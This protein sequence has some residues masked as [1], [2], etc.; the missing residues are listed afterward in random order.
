MWISSRWVGCHGNIWT[1]EHDLKSLYF[2]SNLQYFVE[3]L[4]EQQLLEWKADGTSHGGPGNDGRPC[5]L[6]QEIWVCMEPGNE[7]TIQMTYQY[8][9]VDLQH[10]LHS[11]A[12]RVRPTCPSFYL[13]AENVEHC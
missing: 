10:T 6:A 1:Y 3:V 2:F 9:S 8:Q 11:V 4:R 7:A 12:I 5:T 13:A